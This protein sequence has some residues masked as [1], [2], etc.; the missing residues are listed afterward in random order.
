MKSAC[1]LCMFAARISMPQKSETQEY[2]VQSGNVFSGTCPDQSNFQWQFA[3]QLV[4]CLFP[5][6]VS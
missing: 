6:E 4:L 2:E 3:S 1:G 5:E